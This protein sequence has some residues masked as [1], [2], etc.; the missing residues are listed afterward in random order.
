MS[1]IS[2]YEKKYPIGTQTVVPHG[3]KVQVNTYRGKKGW[4][5]SLPVWHD[6][7][8]K[9]KAEQKEKLNWDF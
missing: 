4:F 7:I 3:H 1:L 8:D 9:I 5:A 6:Q 2:D